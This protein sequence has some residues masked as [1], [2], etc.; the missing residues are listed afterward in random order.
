M[1]KACIISTAIAFLPLIVGLLI[2]HA[3]DVDLEHAVQLNGQVLNLRQQGK[4]TEAV[5]IAKEALDIREKSLGPDHPDVATSL[6]NLGEL[7]RAKA[8][9]RR[10]NRSSSARW[11]S[12][13]SPLA[14]IIPMWP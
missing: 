11:R 8:G 6:N 9:M 12:G 14:R 7:Y 5:P 13:R 3:Q 1:R 2:S 4:Y 10:P